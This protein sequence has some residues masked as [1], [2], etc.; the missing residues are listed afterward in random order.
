MQVARVQNSVLGN[1]ELTTMLISYSD[2]Q[3]RIRPQYALRIRNQS[4]NPHRPGRC[5]HDRAD[6]GD[7]ALKGFSWERWRGGFDTLPSLDATNLILEHFRINPN[8][9]SGQDEV[10]GVSA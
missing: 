2:V 3:E 9:A 4:A 7:L 10:H 6:T 5:V 1:R 8:F